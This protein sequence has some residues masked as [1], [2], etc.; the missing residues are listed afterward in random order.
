MAHHPRGAEITDPSSSIT[1]GLKDGGR[2]VGSEIRSGFWE[3][4]VDG[5]KVGEA[6]QSSDGSWL[7]TASGQQ[8]SR[9][10][11][12]AAGKWIRDRYEE[13]L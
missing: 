9:G 8:A 2:M 13:S 12:R 11:I 5:G 4:F 3:F 10:H 6:S 1:I 7:A